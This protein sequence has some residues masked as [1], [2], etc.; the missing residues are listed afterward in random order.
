MLQNLTNWEGIWLL[1]FGVDKDVI[2][3]DDTGNVNEIGDN[4]LDE[5]LE[6]RRGIGESKWHDQ[7]FVESKVG[8]E[9]SFPFITLSD[10][11]EVESVS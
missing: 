10:P 4:G 2:Q 3:I 11:N 8:M 1:R 6:V 7:H 9:H 5:W